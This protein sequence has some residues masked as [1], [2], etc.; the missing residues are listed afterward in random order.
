MNLLRLPVIAI[1]LACG[2]ALSQ[3][4]GDAARGKL[5]Y[6]TLCSGCHYERVHQR[7]PARSAVRTLPQLRAE[8]ARWSAQTGKPMTIWDQADIVEYLNRSHYR[9]GR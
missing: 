1:L 4:S 7:S 2:E 5:L 6:E 9:L 3:S 8:V